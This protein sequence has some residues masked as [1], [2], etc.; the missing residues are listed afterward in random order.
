MAALLRM[1]LT[2]ILTHLC[3]PVDMP[4]ISGVLGDSA[5]A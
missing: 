5:I 2:A 4:D 1:V 3:K